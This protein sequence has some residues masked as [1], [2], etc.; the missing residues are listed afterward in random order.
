MVKCKAKTQKGKSCKNKALDGSDFC[1]IHQ[2]PEP[3]ENKLQRLRK[4]YLNHQQ[5]HIRDIFTG[6]LVNPSKYTYYVLADNTKNKLSYRMKDLEKLQQKVET[7]GTHNVIKYKS[8][9]SPTIFARAMKSEFNKN[10]E[11]FLNEYHS[12]SNTHK[13][14]VIYGN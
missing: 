12:L 2:P 7:I 10:I 6:D 14:F 13:N 11:T 8:P 3:E 9:V 1:I 4:F 5:N